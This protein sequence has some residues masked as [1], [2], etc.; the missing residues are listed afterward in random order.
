MKNKK[1]YVLNRLYVYIV[2]MY[3]VKG[4]KYC[5]IINDDCERL[6]KIK[7]EDLVKKGYKLCK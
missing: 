3:K 1:W 6:N 4:V 5:D 2:R 7:V